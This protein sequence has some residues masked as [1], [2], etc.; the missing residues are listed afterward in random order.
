MDW[1]IGPDS[2]CFIAAVYLG[3]NRIS[4]NVDGPIFR[5]KQRNLFILTN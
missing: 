3:I 2:L 4:Q 5:G 1:S